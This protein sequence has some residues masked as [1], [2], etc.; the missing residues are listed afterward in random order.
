M[1][2]H[3]DEVEVNIHPC[4][5]ILRRMIVLLLFSE[6]KH[7]ITT[8]QTVRIKRYVKRQT[9]KITSDYLFV[10]CRGTIIK[11]HKS[12]MSTTIHRKC[13]YFHSTVQRAE[14]RW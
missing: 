13:K 11:V 14:D 6:V 2:I 5:P 7:K 1:N 4:S 3:R 8:K 9:A 12:R 10:S